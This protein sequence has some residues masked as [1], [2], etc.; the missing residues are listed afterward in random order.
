MTFTSA[1]VAVGM[2]MVAACGEAAPAPRDP[3]AVFSAIERSIAA[4]DYY[5]ANGLLGS[6]MNDLLA[7]GVPPLTGQA[8]RRAFDSGRENGDL[9]GLVQQARLTW[10]QAARDEQA[11]DQVMLRLFLAFSSAVALDTKL[12]PNIRYEQA[13]TRYEAAPSI[14]LLHQLTL[15]AFE[16]GEY[17]AT[18]T[19]LIQERAETSRL[20]PPDAAG[21][22]LHRLETLAGIVK[23]NAGDVA[24]AVQALADSARV[25]QRY[26]AGGRLREAPRMLL[27]QRLLR[28]GQS[29]P[30][31]AYLEACAQFKYSGGEEYTDEG[32]NPH[33]PTQMISAIREG[34]EPQFRGL[35]IY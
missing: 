19:Y 33:S 22:I 2:L 9:A 24:G 20:Y 30:V 29:A 11:W 10:S 4:H 6:L 34:V 32:R 16:A 28:A 1:S 15:R 17:A 18:A 27:A 26:R 23:L 3:S 14:I 7:A 12:S 21:L 25:L 13:R 35:D 31:L 8:H 5:K